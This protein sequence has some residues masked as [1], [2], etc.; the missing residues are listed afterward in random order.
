MTNPVDTTRQVETLAALIG[1]PLRAE[2]RAGVASYFA[3]AAG[4]AALVMDFPLTADDEPAEA[5]VPI[6]PHVRSGA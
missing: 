4:F 1:L 6:E 3:L 2:H 5:F